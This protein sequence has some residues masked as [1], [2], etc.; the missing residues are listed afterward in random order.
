MSGATAGLARMAGAW[1]GLSFPLEVSQL[2]TSLTSFTWPLS[3]S[4]LQLL[5]IAADIQGGQKKNKKEAV[6]H[7]PRSHTWPLPLHSLDP[8]KSCSPS[9]FKGK[10]IDCLLMGGGTQ[11]HRPLEW[12]E[13][14]VIAFGDHLPHA[15]LE[16]KKNNITLSPNLVLALQS[17]LFSCEFVCHRSRGM[18]LP[19]K[20]EWSLLISALFLF[21][22]YIWKTI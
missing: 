21:Y 14:W 8:S 22:D 1:L 20:A 5:Y 4:L 13:L 2:L 16:V 6:R 3:S 15:S 19:L 11:G 7:P 10:E 12:M 18:W 17:L 9:K